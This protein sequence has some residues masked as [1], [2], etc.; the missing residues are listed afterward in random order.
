VSI[1]TGEVIEGRL[2]PTASMLVK[3]WALVHQAE[4]QANWDRARAKLPLD[5]MAGLDDDQGFED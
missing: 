2:P 4:L 5:R 3:R 1:A